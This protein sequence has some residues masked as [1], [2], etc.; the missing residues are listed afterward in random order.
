MSVKKN[1]R[2]SREVNLFNYPAIILYICLS[3]WHY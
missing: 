1:D 2:E 3:S